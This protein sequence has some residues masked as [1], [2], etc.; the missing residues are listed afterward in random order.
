MPESARG[1]EQPQ[2]PHE[3]P[4]YEASLSGGLSARLDELRREMTSALAAAADEAVGGVLAAVTAI[5][6]AG[7]QADVLLALLEGGSRFASRTAFFL[8]RPGE[9]RGWS[10]HGFGASASAIEGL[11]LDSADGPWAQLVRGAGAVRLSGDDCAEF[12]GRI[13]AAPGREGVLIPFV[14][15]GQ[16]GGALYAD[17]L[18]GE[19]V[20]G[21]ASLQLVTHAAAQALETVAFRGGASPA[22][23]WIAD[24]AAEEAA[25]IPL[26]RPP[27]PEAEPPRAAAAAAEPLPP[28]APAEEEAAAPAPVEEEAVAAEAE[29][30]AAAPLPEAEMPEEPAIPEPAAEEPEPAAEL[31]FETPE[32][33]PRAEELAAEPEPELEDTSADIWA[34]EEEEEPARVSAEPAAAS[35]EPEAAPGLVGQETVRLD[36]AALRDQPSPLPA[37]QEF[38]PPEPTPAVTEYEFEAE[39]MPAPAEAEEEPTLVTAAQTAPEPA[40][41][42]APPPV[43]GYPPA[44]PEPAAPEPPSEPAGSSEVLPPSDLEGPGSAFAKPEPEKTAEGEEALHEEARRLA[45]LLVSEIKLYNEEIIEEGRRN[46]DIYDRLKDDIDRSRQMYEERIDPRLHGKESYFHQ[47]LVQRLAGGDE[48]LL[49]M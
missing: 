1:S 40:P 7:A 31:G 17:R 32:V 23:R 30:E 5:D 37:A 13:G 45:R 38:I 43:A 36:V 49:G 25:G 12:C 24:E 4:R 8:T 42:A 11:E 26:W 27:E 19:G 44:A 35:P 16:L 28:A 46:R 14:L 47:E 15:R 39:P 33:E 21:A 2:T 20:L 6:D 41:P 9:M 48:S 18:P 10:S 22:L 29:P 34:L 3:A